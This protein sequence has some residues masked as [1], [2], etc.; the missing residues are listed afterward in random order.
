M[1]QRIINYLNANFSQSLVI[2]MV[3]NE[4]LEWVD[5]DW[6]EDYESEYDWYVDHNNSEAEN[7]V[8]D[9]LI[10][11]IENDFKDIPEEIDLVDLIKELYEVLDK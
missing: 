2:D 11:A 9:N 1:V 10:K 4:I 6:S 5:P 3:D 7:V 8:I